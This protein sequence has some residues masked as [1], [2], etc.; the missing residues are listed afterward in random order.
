MHKDV[1][2][3]RITR[4]SFNVEENLHNRTWNNST[5]SRSNHP[6]PPSVT[7]PLEV[8]ADHMNQA[9]HARSFANFFLIHVQ[10]YRLN[11]VS[12]KLNEEYIKSRIREC[13]R[14]ARNTWKMT[15][16]KLLAIMGIS[17]TTADGNIRQPIRKR[18]QFVR[19]DRRCATRQC[20]R[21]CER[22]Q[23]FSPYLT[24]RPSGFHL[25]HVRT[26]QGVPILGKVLWWQI[27]I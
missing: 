23:K 20:S 5:Q 8:K 7:L 14:K 2:G 22:F 24:S 11:K 25:S 15:E 6:P 1:Y 16:R 4:T 9:A 27:W 17:D 12:Q 19:T 26:S 3:S 18:K 10:F 21:L 13:R